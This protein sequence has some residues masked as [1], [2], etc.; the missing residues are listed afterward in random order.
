MQLQLI[1]SYQQIKQTI[2]QL[3]N[4]SF[5]QSSNQCSFPLVREFTI[6]TKK[7]SDS[8]DVPPVTKC[9]VNMNTLSRVLCN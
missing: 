7:V 9:S 4:H 8:K 2:N 6:T 3:I 5:N 1:D